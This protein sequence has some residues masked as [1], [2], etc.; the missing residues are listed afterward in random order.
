LKLQY[1]EPVSDFALKFNLRRYT[2][3]ALQHEAIIREVANIGDMREPK[4]CTYKS[5]AGAYTHTLFSST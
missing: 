5:L 2:V 3:L 1:D 4:D